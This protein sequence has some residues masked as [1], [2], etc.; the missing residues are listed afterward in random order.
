MDIIQSMKLK[1][2]QQKNT[3]MI[4]IMGITLLVGFI[5]AVA[6]SA[7]ST[8]YV[9]GGELIVATSLYFIFQKLLKKP[10]VLAYLLVIIFYATN[11]VFILLVGASYTVF[12]IV[13]FISIFAAIQMNHKVFYTGFVVGLIA[14]ATNYIVMDKENEVMMQLFQY[15]A[16]LFLLVGAIFHVLIRL[17]NK[18]MQQL[19]E[20][21]HA[22]EQD[23]LEKAN[24]KD[25]VEK[26]ITNVLEKISQVNDQLQKNVHTQNNLN[27]TIQEISQASQSQAEQISDISNATNDTRQNIDI[28]EQTSQHLYNESTEA[29]KL[30]LAGKEKM[31]ILNE[32]NQVLEKTIGEL[33]RS[34]VELTEKIKETNGFADTI[35]EITEQTNLLAL[36]ASIE[37]ARAGEA[38]KGFA[39]VADEIRKLADLTGETAEK[40]TSNLTALNQTNESAVAQMDKSMQNFVVGI[41]TSDEVTG[42]FENLTSTIGTLNDA[43]LN[44]S[45]LAKEVQEQSNG[46]DASTNDLAAIIEEASASLE[47]MSVTITSLTESNQELATLLDDALEDSEKLKQEF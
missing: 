43:L 19:A 29:S 25:F 44:F 9:Y 6:D 42:Y 35:K 20:L 23:S 7:T 5:V 26:S 4:I 22:S 39:V 28:V 21:L 12:L 11:I 40:I 2:V 15:S 14:L 47:E 8:A 13:I 10:F 27:A 1:E 33:S 37:A 18:Q 46:V 41:E 30:T 32:N 45:H 38:G 34:F 24:Q 31:D 16:L 17:S 36:N 3:L